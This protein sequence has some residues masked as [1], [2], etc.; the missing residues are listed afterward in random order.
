LRRWRCLR[1]GEPAQLRLE[2]T[3]TL[4]GLIGPVAQAGALPGLG[5]VEKDQD[6]Q[7]DDRSQARVVP[8]RGDQ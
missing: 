5:E 4:F 3:H 8:N 1:T 6:R 2:L 7:A